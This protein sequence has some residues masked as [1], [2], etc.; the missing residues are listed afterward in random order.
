MEAASLQHALKT[1]LLPI[2]QYWPPSLAFASLALE[3]LL[4]EIM[5]GI[6]NCNG[7]KVGP[8]EPTDARA[9][10]QQRHLQSLGLGLL[11]VLRMNSSHA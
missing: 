2:G 11:H 7:G 6:S 9:S 4:S 1:L 10:A 8:R 3:I 5:D